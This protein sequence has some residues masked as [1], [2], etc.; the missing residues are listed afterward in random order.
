MR[1][2]SVDSGE[3]LID[4]QPIDMLDIDWLRN[5]VTLVQQQS[6]LFNETIFKNIAF[7]HRDHGRIRKEEVKRAIETV[8][9]QHTISDLPKGLDTVVGVDGSAL[10]GGQEQRVAIARARLRDTPILILDEA[11]SALDHI[12]KSLIVDAIR[13]WRQ[14]KTTIVITHDMSQV[15]DEDYTYVLDSGVVI[16]E[17]L[18]NYLEKSELGPFQQQET[19]II[20]FPCTQQR[21][22]ESSQELHSNPCTAREA[23]P[24]TNTSEMS[25]I[26]RVQPMTGLVSSMLRPQPENVRR[27][28]Q[29]FVP[30]LSPTS[31]HRS[32]VARS[33]SQS[34][35]REISQA[36]EISEPI[37]PIWLHDVKAVEMT[38]RKG[39][40][41][42]IKP[43][44]VQTEHAPHPSVASL[45]TPTRRTRRV[46]PI[47]KIMMTIWPALT[48]GERMILSLGFLCAA[49]H[50]AATPIFSWVFSKLLAT[51]YLADH[52]E[53]S[54]MAL[55]WSLTVLGIAVVDSSAAFS[56][57]FLLEYCGQAWIDTLRIE[58]FKRILDQPRS[59]FAKE[60]NCVSRLTE[61]LDRNAED[62]R[63]L[64]GRFAGYVAVAIT[65]VTVAIIWS[66]ILSWKLTL[67]GLASAPF[68]YVVTRTFETI[69]SHWE[70]KS[71]DAA[72][73]ANAI[74][75]E[76]FSNIRTVRALTLES[77]LKKKYAKAVTKALKVGLQRSAYSGFFF[78]LSESGIL[79]V[80]A[81]IFYYGAVL[82]SS[83]SYTTETILTV[84]TM[85]LFS[86]SQA[87]TLIAFVPQISSSRDTATRLLR[88]AFLP[89]KSSHE[90]T[91]H[92][93]LSTLGPITFTNA[94]FSYPTRPTTHPVLSSLNLTLHPGTTIALVG[95]SGSGKST[96][97]NLLLALYPLS[98]GTLTINNIPLSHLHIPTLRSLITI[99]PQQPTLFPAT[100]AFNITYGLPESSPLTTL[101][102]IRAAALA[103]GIDQF[104]LSLP[105]GYNTL[106]GS[107]GTGLSGGQIQRIAIARAVIGRPQLLVLDEATSGLDGE[108]ARG[109]RGLMGRLE[110]MGV[111]VLVI[112]HERVMM[113]AC[114]EV[115]VMRGGGV[116]ERGGFAEVVGRGGELAR[117]MG[118]RGGEG[119]G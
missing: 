105:H 50:A 74:F 63:N 70:T 3:I 51:L 42:D 72:T 117:L 37:S 86:I 101:P 4:G 25:M 40:V 104:I 44:A 15:Q 16:Q 41:S 9:L 35:Q 68:I 32:S 20:N 67:I 53:R 114:G 61:C 103:A 23:S 17:G 108:T 11:T 110:G 100:V 27:P 59:W 65:M 84:L 33:N 98:S 71:N 60:E 91:G 18:Q 1:F 82:V 99:V 94:T 96:I 54:R 64:L 75:T 113:E 12:S 38:E 85:L 28:A 95:A 48:W 97:A 107:G 83:G 77:Y 8:L 52:S 116:V 39:N 7:G 57:H 89:Y 118:V 19:S 78:G 119:G 29:A 14:G 62:M 46:P 58:A 87:N 30:I 31:M 88:L 55:Q 111:G 21:Y 69:S 49:V 6:V 115:V 26:R 80:T 43:C 34:H 79:F 92:I 73:S 24:T 102:S 10:S 112:T 109:V 66:L 13:E 81:L 56:M 36:S 2:Y 5:N 22:L 45:R 76:T 90:H 93:R 47:K 106:I